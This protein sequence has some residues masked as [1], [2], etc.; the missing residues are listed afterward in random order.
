MTGPQEIRSKII[1]TSKSLQRLK[2]VTVKDMK[3]FKNV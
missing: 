1:G 3:T 2:Q